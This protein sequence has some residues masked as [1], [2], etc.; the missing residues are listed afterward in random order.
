MAAALRT[1]ASPVRDRAQARPTGWERDRVSGRP[2]R[3][4]TQGQTGWQP[5]SGRSGWPASDLPHCQVPPRFRQRLD[6]YHPKHDSGSGQGDRRD[7]SECTHH[8]PPALWRVRDSGP[9]HLIFLTPGAGSAPV[10]MPVPASAGL[11]SCHDVTRTRAR[12]AIPVA[13]TPDTAT[14]PVATSSSTAISP[15]R[16][17]HCP[18][19]RSRPWPATTWPG[20]EEQTVRLQ[21]VSAAGIVAPHLVGRPR[22][23]PK[24]DL[25]PRAAAPLVVHVNAAVLQ[26]PLLNDHA[27][28]TSLRSSRSGLWYGERYCC[29]FVSALPG[30]SLRSPCWLREAGG[31]GL[32]RLLE[33][34]PQPTAPSICSSISRFSS[35][36]YSIGSS[37]A[38]GSTKPRTMVAAASSSVMPRL[39]R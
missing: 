26:L 4:V 6:R 24:D 2:R 13:V 17:R 31:A 14:A 32:E 22:C 8:F 7:V 33:D 36:A 25:G 35:S 5:A 3:G 1:L 34:R 9:R 39:M 29:R 23:S 15:A 19:N 21:D 18:R 10:L 16:W 27:C 38:M 20:A 37:R 30:V 12:R 11:P 28:K